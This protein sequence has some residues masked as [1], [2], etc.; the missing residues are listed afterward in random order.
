[1][2]SGG[3]QKSSVAGFLMFSGGSKEING[4]KWVNPYLE[5]LTVTK[6]TQVSK[7]H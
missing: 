7:G 1:M 5:V 3:D 4:M 2:L 6:Q